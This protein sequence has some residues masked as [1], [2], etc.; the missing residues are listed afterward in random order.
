M[1][2]RRAIPVAQPNL[3]DRVV[4]YF[5]P[6]AG[7]ARMEAR[8]RLG[9]AGAYAGARSDRAATK[10][11][12]ASRGSANADL[13]WDREELTARG[14]DLVRNNPLAAG[15]TGT[16][17]TYT[18]GTG[19]W[20]QPQIDR[21]MLGLSEEEAD[22]LELEMDRWW[23]AWVEGRNCD[24]QRRLT[25]Q[26][27]Q[28][29]AFRSWLESGDVFAVRRYKER[30]G[31]LFGFCL[32]L[33]EADRV[34]TPTEFLADRRVVEGI[35][36]DADGEPLSYFVA[37]EHPG[38]N[39]LVPPDEY[40]E[41]P[42]FDGETGEWIVLHLLD[43]LRPDQARGVTFLYPV[44]EAL[45]TLG[46]YA[47]A[48]ADAAV[49][50]ALFTVF[51]RSTAP[52]E[53]DE[54]TGLPT[55]PAGDAAG[56]AGPGA[57]VRSAVKLGKGSVVELDEGEDIT[58]AESK[59][60]SV[61]FGPF[62]EAFTTHIAMA[63]G[64][65]YEVLIGRFLASY[66]ASRASLLQAWRMIFC[67]RFTLAETFLNPVREAVISEAVARGYL[68]APGFFTSP[69][70][71]R[72]YLGCRWI[73]DPP[74]QLD[75]MKEGKAAELRVGNGFSTR[76]QETLEMNG[77]DFRRNVQQLARE[78]RLMADAGITPVTSSAPAAG[79]E[80]PARAEEE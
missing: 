42:A 52:P 56:A 27:M 51:V 46:E 11:W 21:E 6:S 53:A 5:S 35:R 22:A 28:A 3:V 45:R 19:L 39:A 8:T 69:L 10:N 49:I 16:M 60:P 57:S 32:Q 61:N 13:E 43:M 55:D 29:L 71:R 70:R 48:E 24:V 74:G 31:L 44:V 30:A 40:E 1:N 80:P 77:G 50:N 64:L 36:F 78:N 65:P 47:D 62:V 9:I 76:S 79:A 12:H 15:A 7:L 67:R 41:L 75:P 23:A 34:R 72:A 18:V 58:I 17:V 37:R 25:F 54:E 14:R 59:R 2:A 68:R 20:P 33:V 26:Q 38:D 73:G 66:S 4:S 63:T